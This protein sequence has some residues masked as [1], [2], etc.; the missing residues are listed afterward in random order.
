MLKTTEFTPCA[1]ELACHAEVVHAEMLY[2]LCTLGK[3]VVTPAAG[4]KTFKL[5]MGVG[6]C[7]LTF[8]AGNV[9]AVVE[10]S[11]I[12]LYT[13]CRFVYCCVVLLVYFLCYFPIVVRIFGVETFS[14]NVFSAVFAITYSRSYNVKEN[15]YGV[16][17]SDNF[18]YL[19]CKHLKIGC[20]KTYASETGGIG[21]ILVALFVCCN[22]GYF[23]PP[24]PN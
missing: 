18:L 5:K 1:V 12:R 20:V 15:T 4:G 14:N 11:D 2:I 23:H 6:I 3:M 7:T 8:A 24:R 22:L 16:K 10:Y 19:L 9:T 13:S 17:F 21:K